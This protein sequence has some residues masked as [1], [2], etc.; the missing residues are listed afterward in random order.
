MPKKL[1]RH[2]INYIR[3]LLVYFIIAF[4]IGAWQQF[5]GFEHY[6]LIQ[7]GLGILYFSVTAW[8][9]WR[10]YAGMVRDGDFYDDD[11]VW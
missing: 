11:R 5:I 2:I 3:F 6:T 7:W 10:G 1:K 8:F 4:A 9:F